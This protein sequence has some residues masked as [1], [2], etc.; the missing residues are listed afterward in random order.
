[1]TGEERAL[2]QTPRKRQRKLN[3]ER[4]KGNGAEIGCYFYKFFYCISVYASV[5]SFSLTYYCFIAKNQE[6]I[7]AGSPDGG[8]KDKGN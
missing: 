5:S 3:Q 2:I 1:M 8:K 4:Y 7:V 6:T